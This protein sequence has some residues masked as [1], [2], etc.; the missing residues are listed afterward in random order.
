MYKCAIIQWIG[1]LKLAYKR[2]NQN[3]YFFAQIYICYN[4]VLN[5]L[6]KIGKLICKILFYTHIYIVNVVFYFCL[7]QYGKIKK[8]VTFAYPFVASSLYSHRTAICIRKT[9][10]KYFQYQQ[11]IQIRVAGV[12][13]DPRILIHTQGT[14]CRI[15]GAPVADVKSGQY[16]GG[17]LEHPES[18][19]YIQSFRSC[20]RSNF[21]PTRRQA[22]CL[23]PRSTDLTRCHDLFLSFFFNLTCFSTLLS[24]CWNGKDCVGER[25]HGSLF[26]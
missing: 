6:L 10:P 14:D 4:F 24:I 12:G 5:Q 21:S 3:I 23:I 16:K 13:G 26:C 22:I 11:K 8:L 18:V 25:K 19:I 7:I 20:Q 1:P 9:P 2:Y 17:D 15:H